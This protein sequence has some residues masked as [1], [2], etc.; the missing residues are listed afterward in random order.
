MSDVLIAILNILLTKASDNCVGLTCSP[1]SVFLIR[2]NGTYFDAPGMGHTV[3]WA[4]KGS[5]DLR[6]TTDEQWGGY[7]GRKEP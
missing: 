2:Q 3:L 7:H 6:K 4:G 1:F 5:Q